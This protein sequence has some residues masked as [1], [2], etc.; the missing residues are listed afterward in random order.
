MPC[1]P[2]SRACE[3]AG[4]GRRANCGEIFVCGMTSSRAG[5]HYL[6]MPQSQ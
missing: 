1:A 3:I 4:Q 6:P 5:W 2:V